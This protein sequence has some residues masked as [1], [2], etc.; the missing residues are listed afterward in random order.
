MIYNEQQREAQKKTIE[1]KT[2]QSLE[3]EEAD[4]TTPSY[5]VMTF[6][7]GSEIAFRL[8]AELMN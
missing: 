7:D 1:G 3:Y 4:D 2:I 8:M 6:T 5:W